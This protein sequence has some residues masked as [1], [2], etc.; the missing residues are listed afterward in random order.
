MVRSPLAPVVT[1]D[2]IAAPWLSKAALLLQQNRPSEAIALLQ[3]SI[4]VD[5]TQPWLWYGISML[6]GRLE[7]WETALSC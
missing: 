4:L 3:H 2:P 5:P 6:Y 1:P 7:R